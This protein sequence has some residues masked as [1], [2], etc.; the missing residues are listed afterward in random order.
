[1]NVAS[2]GDDL[3]MY[4]PEAT[5]VY[6]EYPVIVTKY[7]DQAKA[8]EMGTVEEQVLYFWTP[9]MLAYALVKRH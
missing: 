7:I 8:I 2:T 9:K 1:M 6:R 4:L 5:A 3:L